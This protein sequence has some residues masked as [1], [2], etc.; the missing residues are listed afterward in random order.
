[1]KRPDGAKYPGNLFSDGSPTTPQDASPV[2]AGQMNALF[3]E[4]IEVIEHAE[5]TPDEND[6]TQ[7]R[8]SINSLISVETTARSAADATLQDN[9]DAEATT[10][11]ENDGTETT[12]RINGDNALQAA[13]DGLVISMPVASLVMTAGATAPSGWIICDG[14]AISRTTYS[15]LFAE[16]GTAYGAG[17]GSTT[18]N[19][20]DMRS[21]MPVG[22]G[23][24]GADLTDR[25]LADSG[26]EEN[27][28]LTVAEMPAHVHEQ[29][30]GSSNDPEDIY[31]N[32][33][34]G[35]GETLDP[36]TGINTQ[37]SGG[38]DA[39]NNMPPFLAVNFII[40]T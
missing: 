17:N 16:I 24:G 11:A 31:F 36:Q 23:D 27:H 19:V 22:V 5:I 15:D 37:S 21:R 7:V 10:R 39:H 18:F 29:R 34:S 14:A 35:F 2:T 1:M 12:D 30:Y 38:G 13:I 4:L 6:L 3:G 25:A 8:Q 28:T 32:N 9:I 40:K 33:S 20:P 26:G